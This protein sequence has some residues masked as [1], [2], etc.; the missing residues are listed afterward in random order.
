MH[1]ANLTISEASTEWF[2]HSMRGL[3]NF[4][5]ILEIFFLPDAVTTQKNKFKLPWWVK[6]GLKGYTQTN[7]NVTWPLS[8]TSNTLMFMGCQQLTVQG[9]PG[10]KCQYVPS[11]CKFYGGWRELRSS[12][13]MI[14]SVSFPAEICCLLCVLYKDVACLTSSRKTDLSSLSPRF[15]FME[16]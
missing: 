5:E 1:S 10:K 4:L 9:V 12:W 13:M 15:L 6:C 7:G 2:L 11:S 16:V 8:H 3:N 14:N